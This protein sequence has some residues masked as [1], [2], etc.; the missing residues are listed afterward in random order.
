MESQ[1]TTV[2][3]GPQLAARLRRAHYLTKRSQNDIIKDALGHWLANPRYPG[4]R[5][6]SDPTAAFAEAAAQAAEQATP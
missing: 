5:L 2:R 6:A 4:C 3:M 1:K